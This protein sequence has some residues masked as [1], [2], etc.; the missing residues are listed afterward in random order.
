MVAIAI[1][2]FFLADR[3]IAAKE[4]RL[5]ARYDKM[6]ADS[7]ARE[8]KSRAEVRQD[9]DAEIRRLQES[10]KATTE[11]NEKLLAAKDEQIANVTKE[12]AKLSKRVDELLRELGGR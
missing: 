5:E 11:A 6:V 3:R 12:V 10:Q 1:I 8:D 7:S 9:R 2:V 4:I